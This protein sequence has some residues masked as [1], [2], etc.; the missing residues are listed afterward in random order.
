[1][2]NSI[3]YPSSMTCEIVPEYLNEFNDV[4]DYSY[5]PSD[6]NILHEEQVGPTMTIDEDDWLL[7]PE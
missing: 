2:V 4:T 1:M 3:V 5:D 6:M 7:N